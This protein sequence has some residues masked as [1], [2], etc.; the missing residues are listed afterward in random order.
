MEIKKINQPLTRQMRKMEVGDVLICPASD[1][2]KAQA[3]A[4]RFGFQWGMTFRTHTNREN[5]T[6]EIHR[7]S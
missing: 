3:Y 5:N 4:S 1:T 2:S 6:V 7:L